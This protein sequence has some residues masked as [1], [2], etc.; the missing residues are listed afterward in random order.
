LDA[1]PGL[2][3]QSKTD[4][5]RV[6]CNALS[7]VLYSSMALE[8]TFANAH[9]MFALANGKRRSPVST[10][11]DA[12]NFKFAAC[13]REGVTCQI[14]SGAKHLRSISWAPD[15]LRIHRFL[16]RWFAR[17]Y[18]WL[19]YPLVRFSRR[20]DLDPIRHFHVVQA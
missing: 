8:F 20:D 4:R 9:A 19:S 1:K 16:R 15:V 13:A 14:K 17:R 5:V 10:Q 11:V 7:H 3:G 6:I 2:I 12:A 18:F